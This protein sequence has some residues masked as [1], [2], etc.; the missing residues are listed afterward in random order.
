MGAIDSKFHVEIDGYG[1]MLAQMQRTGRFVYGRE[2]APHFVNKMSSGDP[3]YRDSTFFPHWVQN[4]WLNGFDQEKWNDGGRFYRS[5][6]VDTTEQEVLKLENNFSSIGQT[7]A[8]E[9][10]LTQ[11]AWRA[12]SV[13]AFELGEDGAL[14][15]SADTTDAPIDSAATISLGSTTLMATNAGFLSGQ[16]ILI[17]QTQGTGAGT[18]LKTKIVS[19]STGTIT[20]LDASNAAYTTGA[21][22]IVLKRYTTVTIDSG[23]TLTAKAWEGTV[24]GILGFIVKT[25]LT[26]TGT[27]TATGKGY[28][29]GNGYSTTAQQGES[30]VAVGS[31]SYG[32]ND[33][34][35]GGGEKVVGSDGAG[36]GGGGHG[37]A[38]TAG[39][40]A[41]ASAGGQAGTVKGV[42]SLATA[43][44]GGGGGGGSANGA[45]SIG[46]GGAGGGLIFIVGKALTVTGAITSNGADG[47]NTSDGDRGSGGGGAGGSVLLK[48]QTATL[49]TGLVTA[50]GGAGGTTGSDGGAGAVGR[51]HIDYA[52]SFTGT[53]TPTIDS[54]QDATLTDTPASSTFTFLCGTSSGKIFSW[55]GAT[56]FTELFNTRQLTQYETGTDENLIIGDVGGVETAQSQGFKITTTTKV[57]SIQVYIKKNAG[58]PGDITVRIETDSSAKPSGTLANAAATATIPAFTTTTYGWVTVDFA[59]AFSLT[60]G[61]TYHVV[62][63]TAAASNDNNY[64]WAADGSSPTYTDGA[65][66]TST[67]GGSTW[68]A[69]ATKDA[70]FRILGNATQVNCSLV[71]VISGTSKVYFGI[72]SPS[73]TDAGDGRIITYDGTSWAINYTFTGA[74]EIAVMS[75]AEFG[76]TSKLYVGIG[77]IAKVYTTTDATTYTLAKTITVPNNPGFV[78]TMKE[79]GGRLYVGGGYPSLLFGTSNQFSGFLYS[80]DEYSWTNVAP[81]EFTVVTSLWVFDN[82]LFIG[83]INKF[84]FVY[85]TASMDKLFEF[86]WDVQ[87]TDMKSW[88]DKLAI[89][90]APTPGKSASGHEGIYLFDRNGF[91]NAF[92][93]ASRSWYSISTFNNNLMAGNDDGSVYQTNP[94]TYIS[95]GTLQ[96]S[97]FEASLPSME[98]HWR[99]ISIISEALPTGCSVLVQYKFDESDAS[100]TTIDTYDTVGATYEEFIFPDTIYSKKISFLLTLTTTV[101]ASTPKVK[102]QDIRYVLSPT[103]KYLW[104]MK[105]ACPDNIVWLDGTE[106]ISVAP[107][108]ISAGQATLALADG[109]GFP[110][111]GRAIVEDTTNDEFTWTG[112]SGD[113]LTGV[114]GLLQHTKAG[115][116]VKIT[117]GMLHKQILEMKKTREFYTYTDIDGLTYEVLFHQFQEDGFI[118]NQDEG[119]ENDVP[120]SLL[121][122]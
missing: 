68:S 21:Q 11:V 116:T 26:V 83:T 58:T 52:T 46:A 98:K 89:A 92:N 3:N 29:G 76:L 60:G 62:Q 59:T 106:P 109:D 55:D 19:Y 110:T 41:G 112:K 18:Y 72:G 94:T 85:N 42:A 61:A 51:I 50:N 27:I 113:T 33:Q 100:W 86:P 20:I 102:V 79:Y 9:N 47:A 4:N 82:L 2:E 78:L 81:F 118:V 49:G 71:S 88:D 91:H 74:S 35:G 67:D 108:A 44:F 73:A 30:S 22:V 6:R 10:I 66:S 101:P 87:I 75:M 1:F 69:V 90:L 17:H 77:S 84:L 80:Y 64:A 23:K 38:G 28:R 15:I 114:T 16:V 103:F 93:V 24:G 56:T 36:G 99:S 121:E 95:S 63:K 119:I 97:Y 105:F 8:G 14:T 43:W 107:S 120:V 40:A 57:K 7:I 70:Y 25:S 31:Y 104:K 13:S 96:T 48:A 117:G 111:K 53:S 122:T 32:A 39:Q 12:G 65:M 115:L 5:S 54:K 37:A 34:G 45:P